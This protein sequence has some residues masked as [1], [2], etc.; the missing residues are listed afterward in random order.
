MRCFG[1]LATG[2]NRNRVCIAMI[3]DELV[4]QAMWNVDECGMFANG[5]VL[6]LDG[7]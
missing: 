5:P 6:F 7:N 2:N 3:E 1:H 4:S